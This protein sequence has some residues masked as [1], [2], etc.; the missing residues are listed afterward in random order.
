MQVIINKN[1]FILIFRFYIIALSSLLRFFIRTET[2]FPW[3]ILMTFCVNNIKVGTS[4][5]Y[6]DLFGKEENNTWIGILIQDGKYL[7]YNLLTNVVYEI[8][9]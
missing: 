6:V 1:I 7:G 2:F 5:V 4:I 8:Q 9:A 3:Y